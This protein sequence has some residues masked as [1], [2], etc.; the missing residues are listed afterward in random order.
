VADVTWFKVDDQFWAHPKTLLLSDAAV[1]LWVKAGA[2]SAQHLT[3]GHV[4][5]GAL[6][7]L[8]SQARVAEELVR[9]GLW[10][11]HDVDGWLFHDWTTYQPTRSRVLEQRE[12]WRRKKA[13]SRGVSPGDTRGESHRESR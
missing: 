9:A 8:Q 11:H 12:F 2:W 5:A 13:M 4:P 10:L 3:D 6:R 1:A 7:L